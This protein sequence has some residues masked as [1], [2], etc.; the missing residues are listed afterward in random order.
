MG[1]YYITNEK[2][3]C[4]ISISGSGKLSITT[5]IDKAEKFASSPKAWQFIEKQIP[6]DKRI[7]WHVEQQDP[8][9]HRPTPDSIPEISS[10]DRVDWDDAIKNIGE[11]YIK[12]SNYRD[13]LYKQLSRFDSEQT[14]ILHACEF[15]KCN[16]VDGYKLYKMLHDLRVKRRWVKDEIR[17]AE[18]ILL[19][20]YSN[21]VSGE[22]KSSF[23][24][25]DSQ[26]YTPRVLK[27]LFEEWENR[28][29]K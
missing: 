10:E 19:N 18:A 29:E 7:A 22:V 28:K 15:Y 14:D 26:Q 2:R 8:N 24:A 9:Y 25:V 1:V 4:Y 21:I 3:E 16:V 11:T 23:T 13:L 12:V 6:Q 20:K 17:R 5:N 27:E